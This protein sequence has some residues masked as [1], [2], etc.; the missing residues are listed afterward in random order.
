MHTDSLARVSQLKILLKGFYPLLPPSI[1]VPHFWATQVF[2]YLYS[3]QVIS[4]GISTSIGQDITQGMILI[5]L[6]S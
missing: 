5:G 3:G 1:D 4:I 2:L 6:I